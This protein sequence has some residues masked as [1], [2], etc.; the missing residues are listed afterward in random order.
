MISWTY[1]CQKNG[2]A[3]L[4][5]VSLSLSVGGFAFEVAKIRGLLAQ[6]RSRR[7]V[8]TCVVAV[9]IVWCALSFNLACLG[10]QDLDFPLVVPGW[11]CELAH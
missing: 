1:G 5:A 7:F 11:D 6:P 3:V 4:L 8:V 9:L 2:C 10:P